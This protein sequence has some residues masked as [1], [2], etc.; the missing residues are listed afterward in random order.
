MIDHYQF[1]PLLVVAS[2][3]ETGMSVPRRFLSSS[4]NLESMFRF[5][6]AS[7]ASALLHNGFAVV[8]NA[9]RG[10][11]DTIT[12]LRSEIDKLPL[13]PNETHFASLGSS[14][15][16]AKSHI[17]EAEL[18]LASAA[19]RTVVPNLVA[20]EQDSA[21]SAMLSVYIPALTLRS[22][23]LKAQHNAGSG[24]CFPIHV[25]SDPSVDKRV[26]TAIL[27]LNENWRKEHGGELRLYPFPLKSPVD[28]DPVDG[29]LVLLSSTEMYHRVM[30]SRASRYAITLWLFGSVSPKIPGPL[31]AEEDC[32]DLAR[33]LLQPLYRK[34][35]LRLA[36]SDEWILSLRDAHPSEQAET[37]VRAHETDV[38]KLREALSEEI[39]RKF[40]H[41]PRD[42]VK[43]V[44]TGDMKALR[45]LIEHSESALPVDRPVAK[46][47]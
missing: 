15:R 31:S 36:L 39:G 13:V 29:R 45:E 40:I 8:D 22:Q 46:W 24:G 33:V 43:S 5:F 14:L 12:Q 27:Y 34:H 26:V 47:L 6:D 20:L 35:V 19:V 30:P 37:A 1:L 2:V 3:R 7:V 41:F 10:G 17:R 23:A 21:L 18:H 28:I 9:L 32:R 42:Q 16:L 4:T 11:K 38:T 25:D 44:L